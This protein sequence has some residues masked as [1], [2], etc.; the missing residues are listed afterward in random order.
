MTGRSKR[1]IR[2]LLGA[3]DRKMGA[4]NLNLRAAVQ[5]LCDGYPGEAGAVEAP[6]SGQGIPL[7][8]SSRIRGL[9]NAANAK[10]GC[11]DET[12][13]A[14]VQRLCDGYQ[15]PRKLYS[16]G[17]LSDLHLQYAAEHPYGGLA[18]FQRALMYLKKKVPFTC[19]AGDLV[20]YAAPAHMAQYRAWVERYA[21]PME[22]Y[23]CA[24]NHETY[25]ALGVSGDTDEALWREFTGK[26]LYY[27][28]SYQRDVFI[29]LGLKSDREEDLFPEGALVW[30]R[31]TLEANK[32]KR[33]FVFQHCP[34]LAD[35]GADPSGQWTAI[36]GG[37][38]GQAFVRILRQYPNAVWFH[39]HTHLTLGAEQYPVSDREVLGYRSVHVPSLV[40]PRFYDEAQNQLMDYYCD[41]WGNQIW[42]SV[43]SEGYIVDVYENKI[44]LRGINFAAGPGRDQ[45]SPMPNEIYAL[46]TTLVAMP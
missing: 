31:D 32:N 8:S 33:C 16:F 21:G 22:L 25:P 23:E 5:A 44:V 19:V 35:R 38:S 36:M 43:L 17:V 2:A 9:L 46:D 26:P 20:S 3:A 34:E 6:R 11:S 7:E 45:V 24:G 40:A 13:T 18:D 28:F 42:G 10:T 41:A 15:S 30:L 37:S 4:K 39:G 1:A 29:M 27:S 14:A 12:V